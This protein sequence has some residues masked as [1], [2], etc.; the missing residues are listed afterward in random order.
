MFISARWLLSVQTVQTTGKK[1]SL[2]LQIK[3]IIHQHAEHLQLG[4]P[5]TFLSLP[6]PETK[7][8]SL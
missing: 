8:A 4:N 6:G 1:N 3:K 2:R 7:S 5:R